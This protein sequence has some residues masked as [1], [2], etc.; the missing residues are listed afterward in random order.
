[1]PGWTTIPRAPIRG[2]RRAHCILSTQY[3]VEATHDMSGSPT[4]DSLDHAGPPVWSIGLV[5]LLIFVVPIVLYSLAPTG[6]LRVGDTILSEGQQQVV[7]SA[8]VGSGRQ[9]DTC[10]LD[11]GNPLII[12]E[13]PADRADG[14]VRAQVQ[15]NQIIDWPFCAPLTEVLLTP[16]QI[17]Q[18]PDVLKAVKDKAAALFLP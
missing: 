3:A 4:T 15:G 13:S 16:S 7:T 9:Q 6:P 17:V 14:K 1:M 5:V 11:S 18:K 8:A 2:R 10:L 12:M